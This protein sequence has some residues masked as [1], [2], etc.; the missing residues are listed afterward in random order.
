MGFR[1]KKT[2]ECVC[3]RVKRPDLV[4]R[5]VIKSHTSDF[6]VGL[7]CGSFYLT[8]YL[9]ELLEGSHAPEHGGGGLL[10]LPV[11]ER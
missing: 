6:Y 1:R 8:R 3:E 11:P 10:P 4:R 7:L 2:S 5:I 9:L